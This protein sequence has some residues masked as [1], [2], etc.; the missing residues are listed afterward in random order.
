MIMMGDFNANLCPPGGVNSCNTGPNVQ[1]VLPDE[2]MGDA[3]CILS[4]RVR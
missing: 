3:S 2:L 1:G 4:H